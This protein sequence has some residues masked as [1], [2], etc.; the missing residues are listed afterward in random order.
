M[1][2]LPLKITLRTTL[3]TL[4]N[5]SRSTGT[6][7][8][9]NPHIPLSRATVNSNIFH[10]A[11][12]RK[13]ILRRVILHRVILNKAIHSKV[14]YNKV[15]SSKVIHHNNNS[16]MARLS[17]LHIL[18]KVLHQANTVAHSNIPYHRL[19]PLH[20]VTLASWSRQT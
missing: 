12:L 10:R 20:Q 4:N 6:R 9:N 17:N 7:L 18:P 19:L 2:N 3:R 15:I 13:A 11:T 8:L 1:A 14:I 16:N 5:N